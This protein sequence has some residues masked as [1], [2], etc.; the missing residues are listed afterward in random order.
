M[1]LSLC[2]QRCVLVVTAVA[3]MMDGWGIKSALDFEGW[4]YISFL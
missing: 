4:E 3:G 1:G 2:L